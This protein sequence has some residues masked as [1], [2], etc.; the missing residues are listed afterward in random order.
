[1]AKRSRCQ[2]NLK[3]LGYILLSYGDMCN[4]Q[5][6][7]GTYWGSGQAYDHKTL[8]SHF[9]RPTGSNFST[10]RDTEIKVLQC[11]GINGTL[12]SGGS[13]CIAGRWNTSWVFSSYAIAFGTGSSASYPE[14]YSSQYESSAGA[15]TPVSNLKNLDKTVSFNNKTTPYS[16][17]SRQP[18]AG[19]M[20]NKLGLKIAGYSSASDMPHPDGNNTVFAD[21]HLEWNTRQNFTYFIHF[22]GSNSRIWWK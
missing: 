21:G 22:Y 14:G 12:A 20:G 4:G 6:P 5:G 13:G 8:L 11:P 10:T 16:S 9:N 19:D 7:S 18:I 17:P 2:S 15:R 1:M 3:Q